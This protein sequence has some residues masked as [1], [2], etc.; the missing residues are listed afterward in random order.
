MK[1]SIPLVAFILFSLCSMKAQDSLFFIFLN[2][3]PDRY[4]ISK[5]SVEKLQQGH[6][7]NIEQLNKEGKLLAA[8]PFE[9]GGGFFILNATSIEQVDEYLLA[10]PAIQA[11]RFILE[12]FP[13]QIV[14][15]KICSVTGDFNLTKTAFIRLSRFPVEIDPGKSGDEIDDLHYEYWN[16]KTDTLNLLLEMRFPGGNGG[17]MFINAGNIIEAEKIF[18]DDPYLLYKKYAYEIRPLWVAKETFCISR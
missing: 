16:K 12:K 6:L 14:S 1:T 9:G 3:N 2:T 17:T 4:V 11:N 15:G 10:D 18:Q 7:A 13:A 8:G 5:D